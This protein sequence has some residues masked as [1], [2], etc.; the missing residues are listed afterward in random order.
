MRVLSLW[1]LLPEKPKIT[2]YQTDAFH[3]LSGWIS[4]ERKHFKTQ[5]GGFNHLLFNHYNDHSSGEFSCVL[6]T[7]SKVTFVTDFYATRPIYF[8]TFKDTHLIASDIRLLFLLD[9][10]QP[11]LDR[12]ICSVFLSNSAAVCENELSDGRTFYKEVKKMSYLEELNFSKK[13]TKKATYKNFKQ[14]LF[15]QRCA[16]RSKHYEDNFRHLLNRGVKNR[17]KGNYGC[18]FLSGGIDSSTILASLKDINYLEQVVALNLS[19]SDPDLCASQDEAIARRLINDF[20]VKGGIIKGDNILRF[21]NPLTH[22]DPLDC[23]ESPDTSANKLIKEVFAS[24]S[25][26]LG[27]NLFLTGEQGDGLLGERGQF[28][29]CEALLQQKKYKEAYNLLRKLAR[30][31]NQT[32]F[33]ILFLKYGL[34]PFLPF[35]REHFYKANHHTE[36]FSSLPSYLAKELQKSPNTISF[37][38]AKLKSLFSCLGH[39]YI[40]DYFFPR[41]SYFDSIGALIPASHPFI[42]LELFGFILEVPYDKHFDYQNYQ[43]HEEYLHTKTL[44]RKAYKGLLPDYARL[45]KSKTSYAGMARK[46]LSNSKQDLLAMFLDKKDLWVSDLGLV[47]K[48]KF[49]HYLI[50]SL[51]K[52]EDPNNHLGPEYQYLR[53]VIQLE[54][55]LQ[56]IQMPKH[57]FIE[58]T[59]P[60]APR[61][62]AGIEWMRR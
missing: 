26:E 2:L 27:A 60:R 31:D 50:A 24:Y 59:K 1:E 16:N 13:G 19:F 11:T 8:A 10:F 33:I 37:Q 49:R 34:G 61:Q 29:C 43:P 18:L 55:W 7:P 30:A 28:L 4:I 25:I 32:N 5:A 36:S 6:F 45:K 22:N 39:R 3:Y 23:V 53:C 51:I 20:Q 40:F 9:Y 12:E 41:A 52:S 21:W 58:K 62:L 57:E 14:E 48:E 44:A 46:I 15:Q 54:T 17:L 47:N 42:D 56:S 35:L 38:S